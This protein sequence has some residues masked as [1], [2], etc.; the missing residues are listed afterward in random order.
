MVCAS[1]PEVG[2]QNPNRN[3]QHTRGGVSLMTPKQI[4]DSFSETLMQ[5]ER[6]LS[7]QERALVG[8][9][10]AACQDGKRRQPGDAG[11]GEGR[12]CVCG[13]RDSG[14]TGFRRAGRQH[15][16]ALLEAD[17]ATARDVRRTSDAT[18]GTSLREPQP[19]SPTAAPG[20][21]D[22]E[23]R[24][25]RSR[26]VAGSDNFR[27]RL[28]NLRHALRA[29]PQTADRPGPMHRA[30]TEA[31]QRRCGHRASRNRPRRTWF[32]LRRVGDGAAVAERPRLA[33][34][35]CGA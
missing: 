25:N 16:R 7:A 21:A 23:L 31:P 30:S 12:D 4:L 10:P 8:D 18:P 27:R 20:T 13:G 32:A 15:C 9:H 34:A 26:P 33:G 11:S 29:E 6:I 1:S 19:P 22:A 17:S 28:R 14:A 35:M 3:L 5:D 24:A 2:P